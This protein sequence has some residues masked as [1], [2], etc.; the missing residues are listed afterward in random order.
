MEL[1]D[2]HKALLE[3]GLPESDY[4]AQRADAY[5]SIKDQLDMIYKDLANGTTTF[6]DAIRAVKEQFPKE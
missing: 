4:S 6:V 1:S 3:A 2:Y 5:P